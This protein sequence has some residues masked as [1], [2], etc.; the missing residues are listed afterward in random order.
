MAMSPAPTISIVI[1]TYKRARL[2]RRALDSIAVQTLA[3][4]EI[5][6][7]D[8]ASQDDTAQIVSA[9][10]REK[11]IA[12]HLITAAVN[13]GVG[14]ARNLAMRVARGEY[15]AFLDS[16]DAYLPHALEMLS[17]PLTSCPNIILS[18]A[19][20][21]QSWPDNRPLIP[22]M[23]RCISPEEDTVQLDPDRPDWRELCDPQSVLL[24]T[25]MIP[26]CAAIFRRSAAL[27]V[28]LMPEYRHGE[29]WIF[30]LKLSSQGRF[31]CQFVDVATVHRQDDNQTGKAH[32]AR[33]A[34]LS[35]NA[36]LGLRDGRFGVAIHDTNRARLNQAI[37]DKAADMRYHV[38]RQGWRPYWAMLSSAEVTETGGRLHHLL[39]DPKSL[40]RAALARD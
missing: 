20:A 30:W 6:V 21:Q 39:R 32:D 3:P 11:G 27:A 17:G 8:D 38:S 25:S 13:G 19:D 33:N 23:R 1:A 12:V 29:D 4:A 9:W 7:V 37:A 14:S 35:L 40:L 24:T 31:A 36:L 34:Q 22:L 5:I 15:I 16:D 26:T 2:I 18:F 28:G 10:S